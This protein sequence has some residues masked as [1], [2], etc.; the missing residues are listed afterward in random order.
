MIMMEVV[1]DEDE[2]GMY[3]VD[4]EFMGGFFTI[5][6]MWSALKVFFLSFFFSL[7]LPVVVVC[8]FVF[9]KRNRNCIV[10]S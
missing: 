9:L 3:S 1:Y 5:I 6:S 4:E 10:H 8:F 7:Y 2:R